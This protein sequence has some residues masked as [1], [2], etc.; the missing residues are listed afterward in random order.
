M[1]A[2]SKR[3][4]LRRGAASLR[5]ALT[6]LHN[7]RL[8]ALPLALSCFAYNKTLGDISEANLYYL[9]HI[10]RAN[11]NLS[12]FPLFN[13]FAFRQEIVRSGKR[14]YNQH[15]FNPA[16]SRTGKYRLKLKSVL[17]ETGRQPKFFRLPPFSFI[18]LVL[19]P[20]AIFSAGKRCLSLTTR[21]PP[22]LFGCRKAE[23]I[24]RRSQI[25]KC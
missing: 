5:C 20:H 1:S 10:T 2:C 21:P 24:K 16:P 9:R 25:C 18:L 15:I 14:T 13:S 6:R 8:F 23:I 4:L 3:S 22:L 12:P 19:I 7:R 17:F 11:L